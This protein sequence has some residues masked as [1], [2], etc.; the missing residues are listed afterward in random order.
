MQ[1]D[2]LSF[3]TLSVDEALNE[4]NS[5]WQGLTSDD[6]LLRLKE[7]GVNEVAQTNYRFLIWQS[8]SHSI[9][10]LIIIL[11]FAA[12]ISAFTANLANTLI[13]F[14]VILISVILDSYQTHR[15]LQ[16]A[17]NLQEKVATR[18]QVLRDDRLI[19]ILG[20]QIV[21]GDLITLVAGDLVPADCRLLKAKDLHIQQA[22]LTGESIPAKKEATALTTIPHNS[23]D[24]ANLVFS[25]SSVVSGNAVALV[26]RTGKQTVFGDIAFSLNKKAP[27]TEFEKGIL[28]FGLFIMKLVIFLVLFVFL[29][30]LYLHHSP[31]ESLL[32]A[33][34]L[35]VGLT[36]EFLPMITT[37]TL[38]TG[39]IRMA[40]EKVIVKNLEAIQNIG[41]IDILCSDKTGTLTKGEMTLEKAVDIKGNQSEYVML[42]AYL[43][44]L[45]STTIK[46]PVDAAV[47][48]H[49]DINPL[50][51]AI[52]SHDHPDIEP[53]EKC[54]E[55]PF[56]FER[57]AAS[58][59]VKTRTNILLISKGAPEQILERSTFC[60]IDGKV[61]SFDADMRQY[62]DSQFSNYSQQGYRVLA[63]AY[64]VM[65][66]QSSYGI[67]DETALIFAGFLIFLDPPLVDVAATITTLN[68]V[69][70]ELKIITGD[71]ELVTRHVCHTIGLDVIEIVLGDAIDDLTLPALGVIAENT[72]VFAR[73]SPQQKQRIIAALRSRGHAVGYLGDGIND[74]P[75]LHTAD[76]G[77]SV[78][79][80]VDVARDAADIILL[81]RNLQALYTG[82]I[83]GRKSF[84]NVMKYL[85][86]GTSS[87]FGNMLSMAIAVPFL[88]FL[89]M[90][91]TQ[92]LVNN[93]LYDLSQLTIPTDHV[94]ER[95]MRKP[96]HWDIGIIRRF[97]FV[98]GPISSLFDFLT[99]YVMLRVFHASQSLFQ[100]GWFVESLATQA[101]VIFVIRTMKNPFKSRP[102]MPLTLTVITVVLTGILLPFSPLSGLLGFVPLPAGFFVF[103]LFATSSYLYLVNIIKN[104]LISR[105]LTT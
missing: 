54:D 35:A 85:M 98:I 42:Y 91:P 73:V 55:I 33:V 61:Q 49:A 72:Q 1:K 58:V 12:V 25:G 75:S 87:N 16:A 3:T 97:M 51:K 100:T 31:I 74:A 57:R 9:N 60:F 48:A 94:D 86:M 36:P 78:F 70:V 95:F 84:G 101:L 77:I 27:S 65:D 76:V 52:L 22:F 50:D 26:I 45:Y 62:Y 102:S 13:I 99:F 67:N 2:L 44:S 90:Q 104:K 66:E 6:A 79:G 40:K 5:S 71:N 21:P 15:S 20:N 41:S 7:H 18:V 11:F 19:E 93:L 17:R 83:E 59:I 89:P 68:Q 63:V 88:P 34:A 69:G 103:L 32:F 80:A 64:R 81:E 14:T 43:N 96:K 53:Y 29:V 56:D 82:I 92:I 30:N 4:I 24:A 8:V 10:P 46:N 47:L 23:V 28:H 38:A 37:V 39:A 105:W